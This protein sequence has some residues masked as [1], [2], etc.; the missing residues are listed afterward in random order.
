M[1]D[2]DDLDAYLKFCETLR[3]GDGPDVLGPLDDEDE[4]EDEDGGSESE[5]DDNNH[6]NAEKGKGVE[7][8]RWDGNLCYFPILPPPPSAS[9]KK[10][11]IIER[12]HLRLLCGT[13]FERG[14]YYRQLTE[15][16]WRLLDQAVEPVVELLLV[17]YFKSE[18]IL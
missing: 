7:G 4:D 16:A 2:W 5:S 12:E 1:L 6:G 14:P 8:E 10:E 9:Q 17:E 11:I 13:S 18:T 3:I 15:L